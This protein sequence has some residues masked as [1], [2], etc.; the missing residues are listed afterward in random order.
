MKEDDLHKSMVEKLKYAQDMFRCELAEIQKTNPSFNLP[1][2]SKILDLLAATNTS[3]QIN[4]SGV[5]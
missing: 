2:K 3:V 5:A 1:S 4:I